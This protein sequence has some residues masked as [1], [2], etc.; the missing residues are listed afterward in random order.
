MNRAMTVLLL[1][2]FAVAVFAAPVEQVISFQGKI[3][4]SGTPVDGT[5]SIVFRLYDVSSGGTAL[6]L[7]GHP[8]VTVT[9][10]LFNV[11]LGGTTTLTTLS[12]DE[13]YWI[14]ISVAGGLEIT[15]R[16]K[17]T[18]SP[19]AMADGDWVVDGTDI[20]RETGHVGIGTSI[21]SNA[22]LH[23]VGPATGTLNTVRITGSSDTYSALGIY[24]AGQNA[25]YITNPDEDGIYISSAGADGIH[26]ASATDWAGYF[27]GDGYFGG[28]VGI[29]TTAPE[30]PLHVTHTVATHGASASPTV[31]AEVTDGTYTMKGVLAGQ[32][33]YQGVYGET[34]RPNGYGVSG[35]ATGGASSGVYGYATGSGTTN[36]GVKG[37]A[38]GATTN[39]GGYF[40]GDGYFSG[41]VAIGTTTPGAKLEVVDGDMNA[42][43]CK[44]SGLSAYSVEGNYDDVAIGTLGR[45]TSG[46]GSSVHYGVRGLASCSGTSTNYGVYGRAYNG[47]TNYGVYCSGDGGYTSSWTN[48]SDRKFKKNISSMTGIL[49]KVLQLNPVTYEMRAD[50]YDFMG[51]S[52]G[53]E[54]GLIAQELKEVFPE[55]VKHGV[56]PGDDENEPVEYEGIAYIPLTAIL[57]EAV[58]EQQAQIEEL[59]AEIENLK[60]NK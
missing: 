46:M 25:I 22:V 59:K 18:S 50:E 56:H 20:Y 9:G 15:P 21:T 19:Y 14:G 37:N 3:V 58:Q 16:Y 35:R 43:L 42:Y 23:V 30:Y 45:H 49:D 36:Y 34:D 51:F 57:I 53:N 31:W 55:L 12:F 2:A 10:G 41:D 28:N 29:G 40:T 24:N 52:E 60:N 38:S 47:T 27:N 4:E 54:Y 13:Q 26:V 48:V 17:L 44:T 1:V 33:G 7:E 32:N 6:W 8:L 11:E 5:R 39:W